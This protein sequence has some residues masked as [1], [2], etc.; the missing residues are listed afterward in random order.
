MADQKHFNL[1][2]A[3][4]RVQSAKPEKSD[5]NK[6]YLSIKVNCAGAGRGNVYAY[7]R[8]WGQE[9][10]DRFTSLFKENPN[11]IFRFRGFFN[12]YQNRNGD[13]LSNYTW[14]EFDLDPKGEPRAA[15]VLK[16]KLT[17][18]DEMGGTVSLDITMAGN[19]NNSARTESFTVH[20]GGGLSVDS[21]IGGMV[22]L[23]GYLQQGDGE[24]EFGD[25][26]GPVRPVVQKVK[27]AVPF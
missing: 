24:D 11:A 15:F 17:E 20:L 26:E 10:I 7:G 16:G 21:E 4:G 14:H 2:N 27:A 19:G 23:K 13:T 6:P 25:V 1:G 22:D 8:I 5:N 3:W 18:Y 9:R 12:Q